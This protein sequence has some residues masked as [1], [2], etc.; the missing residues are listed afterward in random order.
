LL[1]SFHLCRLVMTHRLATTFVP[2]AVRTAFTVTHESALLSPARAAL[3]EPTAALA[4]S[5]KAVA[6]FPEQIR[7][8]CPGL[9]K[10]RAEGF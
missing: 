2:L 8:I 3:L 6:F 4:E 10:S 1:A 5:C 7:R 9:G